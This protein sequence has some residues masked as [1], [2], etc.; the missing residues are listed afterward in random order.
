[1]ST[2][3]R[4]QANRANAQ[5]S[6]GPRTEA[7]KAISSRNALTH[8]LTSKS[9]LLPGEDPAEFELF[10][11]SMLR[12][13]DPFNTVEAALA[14]ELIDLQWRLQ[15]VPSVEARIL[16][17]ESPDMKAL[18]NM[19]LH[20]AR[21]KRQYSATLKEF[22]KMH[23]ANAEKRQQQ[24]AD[25]HLIYCADAILKRPST[26]AEH[27]FVLTVKDVEAWRALQSCIFE[28]NKVLAAYKNSQKE[29]A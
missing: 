1:V 23:S 19:S 13:L 27:G 16:S 25:A 24:M 29:A 8:G 14:T 20:A 10:S 11:E 3:A 2:E 28:A 26:L 21:M 15:R 7:G 4:D 9:S 6:T 18:N 12:D 17:A 5:F 22:E